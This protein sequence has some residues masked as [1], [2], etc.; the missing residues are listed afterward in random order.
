[1]QAVDR[2]MHTYVDAMLDGRGLFS[3]SG[4]VTREDWSSYVANRELERRYPGIQAIAYPSA[5]P[6]K[7]G[8]PM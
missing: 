6:L 3:A 2:R 7:R 5:C 4:S 8:E 1:V